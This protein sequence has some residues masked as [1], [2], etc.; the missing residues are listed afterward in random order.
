MKYLKQQL[1]TQQIVLL[2]HSMG[3]RM[4]SAFLAQGERTEL[5]VRALI[6]LSNGVNG[7]PP[8]NAASSLKGICLPVLD[9]SGEGDPN[10]SKSLDV[11][12]TAYCG[13]RGKDFTGIVINGAVPHDFAGFDQ[14]V[15]RCVH[16]W[17]AT[18]APAYASR[19]Q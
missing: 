4:H 14:D 7:I 17:I 12:K 13:G 19:S 9:V 1:G 2:G 16:A 10:V 15:E 6:A 11:R 3:A 5:P 8:L 18:V